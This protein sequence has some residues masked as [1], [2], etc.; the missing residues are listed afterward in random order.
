MKIINALLLITALSSC[1]KY[2]DN[3]DLPAGT[4]AGSDAYISDNSVSAVVTSTMS[5]LNSNGPSQIAEFTSLYT[6]DLL[7][8]PNTSANQP[9]QASYA[10]AI[11]PTNGNLNFWTSTYTKLY[12]INLAI[13]GIKGTSAKLYYGNQWLGE[14]YFMRAFSYYYLTNLYGS[15]ALALSSDFNVNQKL[16]RASQT[17]VYAQIVSDLKTAM[18]LLNSGYTNGYGTATSD[19][20]RPNRSVAQAL[21]AKVYLATGDWKDAEIMADSV[22]AQSTYALSPVT[23]V[24][25][26]NST[27]TIWSMATVNDVV[28]NEWSVYNKS[29]PAVVTV[30]PVGAYLVQ[31]QLT[32]DFLNAFEPGDLRYTNWVRSTVYTG[33]GTYYFPNKYKASTNGTERTMILRLADI[34]LLRAEARAR[35]NN[36]ADAQ[37]DLNM[38]RTRAGLPNTTAATTDDLVA[39]IMHERRVELFT[40]MGNRFFDLRRTSTLDGVMNTLKG[41][42]V[43]SGYKQFWPIPPTEITYDPSL[44]QTPGY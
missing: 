9:I 36:I 44:T 13:E 22:I 3:T 33:V 41:S 15:A 42:T 8:M 38:I 40:E 10:D 7:P 6:D 20:A 11:D 17:D 19:R 23:G 31:V 37:A 5:A 29:M 34:Y 27:E 43:W 28:S 35:L 24:F 39:A 21:L 4:I 12:T 2:L 16:S 32:S 18:P 26:T 1:E 30:D 14:C 25:L